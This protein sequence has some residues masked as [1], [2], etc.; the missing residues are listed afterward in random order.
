MFIFINFTCIFIIFYIIILKHLVFNNP[1]PKTKNQPHL[2]DSD[3][4]ESNPTPVQ[5]KKNTKIV[6]PT[7]KVVNDSE[8]E[9]SVPIQKNEKK[10][11]TQK[12]QPKK[13]IKKAPESS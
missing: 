9:S 6:K 7:K 2:Q 1:M 5:T 4:E 13:Q 10:G 11:A 12:V 8:E 3:S